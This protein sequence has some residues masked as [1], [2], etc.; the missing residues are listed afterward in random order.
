MSTGGGDEAGP[1]NPQM[2]GDEAGPPNALLQVPLNN[3]R[4]RDIAVEVILLF[5]LKF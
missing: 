5:L 1:S 4:M 2:T 3:H